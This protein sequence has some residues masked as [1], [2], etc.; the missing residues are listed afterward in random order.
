MERTNF[1]AL[2]KGI[3]GL[4]FDVDGV[5][6]DNRVLLLE[7]GELARSMS[8]RD[9]YAMQ[10]A[11]KKG[12]GL[13]IIS[14]G[15]YD[16]IRA[17]LEKLGIEEVHLGISDKMEVFEGFLERNGLAK[18]EVLYMGDDIP[19]LPVMKE[20]GL[21]ACPYDATHEVRSLCDF[22]SSR[23][24]GEGCVRDATEQVL[25]ARGLWNSNGRTE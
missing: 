12:V 14:G 22:V 8:I 19:D 4:L 15:S 24:G 1:K 18:E 7:S 3:R 20:A 23:K 21:A 11:V 2:L 16:P 9:G 25:K 10:H 13:G 5:L 6:T 17:R